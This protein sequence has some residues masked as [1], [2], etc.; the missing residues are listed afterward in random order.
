[1][2]EVV[3]GRDGPEVD[4]SLDADFV[5]KVTIHLVEQPFGNRGAGSLDETLR[6]EVLLDIFGGPKVCC[7]SSLLTAGQ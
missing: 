4:D 7:V 2:Q 1:L 6:A 3:S 5:A